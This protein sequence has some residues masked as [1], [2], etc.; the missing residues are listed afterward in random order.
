[1]IIIDGL[2][3]SYLVKQRR[4][5]LNNISNVVPTPGKADGAQIS[6]TDMLKSHVEEFIKL[7][8]EV[9]WSKE[10]VQVKISGDAGHK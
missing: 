3:K 1:V 4:G 9:D 10:N 2:P 6:F 8:D 7:H 5:Q